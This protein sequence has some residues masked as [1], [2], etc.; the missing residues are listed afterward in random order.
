L[1]SALWP[2]LVT[3]FL[4]RSEGNRPR[5]ASGPPTI[6][7]F[8][9]IGAGVCT[10]IAS[11]ADFYTSWQGAN[12]SEVVSSA[13]IIVFNLVVVLGYGALAGRLFWIRRRLEWLR[14]R[15]LPWPRGEHFR[16][17]QF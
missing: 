5:Y 4:F 12:H 1:T 2:V 13:K 17:L 14:Q 11:D 9:V 10:L 3:F 15:G 16:F 7:P 6:V 8:T